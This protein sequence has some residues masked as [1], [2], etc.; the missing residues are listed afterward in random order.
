MHVSVI[1]PAYQVAPHV[2]RC[3]ASVLAQDF[4]DMEILV[5]NDGSTDGTAE[6]CDAIAA[7]EARVRVIHQPNRGLV[8]A[9]QAGAA[10][11]TGDYVAC[12]DGDDHVA[13]GYVGGLLRAARTTG[14][15]VVVGGYVREYRGNLARQRP[16]PPPGTYRGAA[17][18]GLKDTCIAAPPFFSHALTTYLWGKL[19]E[20]SLYVPHQQAVPTG[21]SLCE[22]AACLFPLVAACEAVAVTD[23]CDYTYVQH[24]GSM[25]KTT[26][27]DGD[28]ELARLR[29]AVRYLAGHP[30]LRA[31]ASYR[32]QLQ[33]FALGHYL[34]RSGATTTAP[35][36]ATALFGHPVPDG[37]RVLVVGAGTFGQRVHSRLRA[38]PAVRL[39]GWLDD[40]A[41][42]Y[43]LD[44]LPVD[45]VEALPRMDFDLAVI[46][47]LNPHGAHALAARC[48]WL[49]APPESLLTLDD[50]GL[51]GILDSTEFRR[52]QAEF[53]LDALPAWVPCATAV[54]A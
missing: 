13:P 38:C 41:A 5:V 6:R 21:L 52:L 8:A 42:A 34:M 3:L 23:A 7:R 39:A 24:Q 17:L 45:P 54:G 27:G 12:I 9:R 30:A 10:A 15:P 25:L 50:L 40:D 43:R 44:G 20:R 19:F 51:A 31:D 29:A 18:Q 32:S 53:P 35:G 16:V 14:A 46:A 2:G 37:S 4:R 33:A 22:D 28:R 26:Q 11:A 47:T 1:I 48:E 36:G 49:G